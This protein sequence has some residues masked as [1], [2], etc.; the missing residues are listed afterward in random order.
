MWLTWDTSSATGAAAAV[1]TLIALRLL[2]RMEAG[3]A[4]AG[5]A[6]KDLDGLGAMI[7]ALGLI[8][9]FGTVVILQEV[10]VVSM[11]DILGGMTL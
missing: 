6:F 4:T 11:F 1:R 3:R 5:E 2:G 10:I 8:A 7:P 9:H